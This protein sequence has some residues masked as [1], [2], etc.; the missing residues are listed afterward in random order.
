MWPVGDFFCPLRLFLANRHADRVVLK[1][2]KFWHGR[3]LAVRRDLYDGL[4]QGHSLADATQGE[5]APQD[6]AYGLVSHTVAP[7]FEP[8]GF[9]SWS[10]A[11]PLLSGFVAKEA[12]ISTWAQ[13]YSVE[14]V[15]DSAPEEQAASPLS[16]H[17]R[18]DFTDASGGNPLAAVWA[19]MIFLLAYTPCVATMAA[20]RREIGWRWT[21]FGFAIQFSMAWVLAVAVFQV[22]KV[23]L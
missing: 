13:T 15:T 23:V 21:A 5:L 4:W 1:V 11:G 22:L 10:L 7:M 2:G 16:A 6:S 17:V 20:Q 3:P 9:G 8:A 19:Y 18:R 14:D 12:L